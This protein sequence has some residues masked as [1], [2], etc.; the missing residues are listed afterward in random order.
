MGLQ[1]TL[2]K[3]D[4]ILGA[5]ITDAYWKINSVNIYAR[6]E[7]ATITILVAMNKEAMDGNNDSFESSII[8]PRRLIKSV[9]IDLLKLE[10]S[11]NIFEGIPIALYLETAYE[12][13]KENIVFFND[14]VD[15]LEGL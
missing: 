12:Y 9:I 7:A 3:S 5:E 2:P 8:E 6:E 14:A 11:S 13:V 1:K 10:V 15:V 4:S